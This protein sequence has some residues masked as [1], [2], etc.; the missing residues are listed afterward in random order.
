M[1]DSVT[2]A[3]N[4]CFFELKDIWKGF[5]DGRNRI[6]P[7]CT[8]ALDRPKAV[9]V[10]MNH[11]VFMPR[12]DPEQDEIAKEFSK[13]LPIRSAFLRN[14]FAPQRLSEFAEVMLYIFDRVGVEIT[15][16]WMG[17]NRCPVQR[18]KLDEIR[19]LPSFDTRQ[20]QTDIR[21][22]AFFKKIAPERIIL[23]GKFAAELYF[24]GAENKTFDDL[25]QPKKGE[26]RAGDQTTIFAIEYP[27]NMENRGL[28]NKDR[29]VER[30]IKYWA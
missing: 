30:L 17:T 24:S 19:Y 12:I 15:D 14:D 16:T 7:F 1:T 29:A 10:G 21:L 4:D 6:I 9:I 11:S 26:L 13:A 2:A 22:R 28:T 18:T 8:P 3:A 23:V 5:D 25:R 20:K 27:N